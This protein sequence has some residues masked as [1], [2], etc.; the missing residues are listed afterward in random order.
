VSFPEL[1]VPDLRAHLAS[2]TGPGEND[3]L[4][5][6]PTG[7]PLRHGN[8]RRRVWLPALDRASLPGIHFHDLRHTGNTLTANAG[9]NLRELMERMGH[10][11]TRAALIYLHPTGDRQRA[12]ADA[13]GELAQAELAKDKATRSRRKRSGTEVARRRDKASWPDGP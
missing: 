5:T 6:S 13:L 3:L 9:A 10:S 2:S 11:S 7:T 4:F 1:I 8:F 12:L